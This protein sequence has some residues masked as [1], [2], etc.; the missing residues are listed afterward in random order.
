MGEHLA[1]PNIVRIKGR[2]IEGKKG[3][4]GLKLTR[5]AEGERGP[6]SG[7]VDDLGDCFLL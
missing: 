2:G 1:C 7:R 3:R 4:G 5:S 6:S